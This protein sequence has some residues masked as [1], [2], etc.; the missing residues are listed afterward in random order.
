MIVQRR[1]TIVLGS[2]LALVAFLDRA[3]ADSRPNLIIIM[4]DDMGFS[5]IG[6]YGSEIETPELDALA[7]N[8]IRFTQF[9][10]TARCCP[11]RAAL[12]TGLYS[13]QAGVGHMMGDD[14][15]PGYRGDLNRSSVTIAEALKPARYTTLMSGKWHVCRP[16][17]AQENGPIARG[18]DRFYGTIH[19]AGSFYDPATLTL[20]QELIKPEGDKYYYTDAISEYASSFI[21]QNADGDQPFFLYV[22]YTAPHWPL[23]A[24]PEDIAKY[25]GRYD[26]GWEQLRFERFR[27]M[28]ELGIVSSSW[29]ISPRD[30][31]GT[32]W[33]D[34]KNKEWESR[35]ME[36]YAAM[37]DRMDQG[38][39]RIVDQLKQEGVF[40]D[41]LILF[42]ADN[43]GCAE[44]LGRNGKAR[45]IPLETR[46][47]REVLQGNRPELMPGPDH[48]YQSY[49]L[50]WANASN[51]P[52]RRYKH[53]VHEGGISSP[54]IAHWPAGI[55]ESL[56]GSINHSPGHLIDLMATCVDA[57][58]A[59]YPEEYQ[60]N[61]ITPLEGK[62][63]IPLL[64]TG[65]RAGHEAIFWEHEGNRAVRSGKWKLVS[66]Y[67]GDWELY[68]I[69]ADRTE[70]RDLA[71]H[72]PEV[73]DE[74]A[75]RFEAW[76]ARSNVIPW[77]ELHP[78]KKN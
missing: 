63:L 37:I 27:R 15:R 65:E 17:R 29:P 9:Y 33:E 38:I 7:G 45:H 39:G 60:G 44:G 23:H 16:V 18:F 67:P 3:S 40:E 10:N 61:A 62:S 54:L 66:D 30:P 36:V 76:A 41:T 12:L 6:C 43:G 25:Q 71:E 19:G 77:A 51:T 50:A 8:G 35:R 34:A 68:D 47:G 57:A 55:P 31:T 26:D 20:D 52:F 70:L 49:G 5:D 73:V 11:T 56:Q 74:L 46:D 75:A 13:H 4:A 72:H 1:C 28:V 32:P 48:T 21:E 64:K 69:E 42:L 53:W 22:A 2:L 24:L 58:E 78:P 59:T 14:Q